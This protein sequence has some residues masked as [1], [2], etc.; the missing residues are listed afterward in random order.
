[1]DQRNIL[2]LCCETELWSWTLS[3]SFRTDLRTTR[4]SG[5]SWAN[6]NT[7]VRGTNMYIYISNLSFIFSSFVRY[8]ANLSC[9]A[10]IALHFPV[11]FFV[12]PSPSP[13]PLSIFLLPRCVVFLFFSRSGF[14]AS[15]WHFTLLTPTLCGIFWNFRA[16]ASKP[17][18]QRWSDWHVSSCIL[19][20]QVVPDRG[21]KAGWGAGWLDLL[22]FSVFIWYLGWMHFQHEREKKHYRKRVKGE[23]G[24]FIS[25]L[26]EYTTHIWKRTEEDTMDVRKSKRGKWKTHAQRICSGCQHTCAWV[27]CWVKWNAGYRSLQ[28]S[29]HNDLIFLPLQALP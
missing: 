29:K 6:P 2:G 24:V 20:G 7:L 17:G 15:G 3:R 12:H 18:V 11:L 19:P 1:M 27:I 5:W 10:L 4:W 8:S 23:M 22:G 13:P 16:V 25:C 21:G 28:R 9:P 26:A 14:Q